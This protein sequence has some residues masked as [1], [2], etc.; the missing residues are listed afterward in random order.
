MF[1]QRN[2]ILL[3]WSHLLIHF[4]CLFLQFSLSVL[5]WDICRWT[6]QTIAYWHVL[7][8]KDI[9][10]SQ[11][12]YFN[13]MRIFFYSH[14]YWGTV[15]DY[16]E[17]SIRGNPLKCKHVW[18]CCKCSWWKFVFELLLTFCRKHLDLWRLNYP[19]TKG[20]G[21]GWDTIF[22]SCNFHFCEFCLKAEYCTTFRVS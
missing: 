12:S 8:L 9:I 5:L 14:S 1:E 13:N 19:V 6:C 10:V 21:G 3:R 4:L 16:D 18:C 11:N 15:P 17:E 2:C 20:G 7:Q 22:Q